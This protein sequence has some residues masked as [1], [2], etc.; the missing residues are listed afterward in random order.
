MATL[1]VPT[2]SSSNCI[3]KSIYI[4]YKSWDFQTLSEFINGFKIFNK[5]FSWNLSALNKAFLYIIKFFISLSSDVLLIKTS[6]KIFNNTIIMFLSARVEEFTHIAAYDVGADDF[7][8]KPIKPKLLVS[9]VRSLLR[10]VNFFWEVCR[11]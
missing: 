5:S 2:L 9:K 8:N 10:R 1:M 4:K 6:N 11:Q 7:V 3:D